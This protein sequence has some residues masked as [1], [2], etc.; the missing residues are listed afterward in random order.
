VLFTPGSLD[1]RYLKIS[2]WANPE[3]DWASITEA[4]AL[5]L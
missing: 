2:F 1:A 5:G 4:G 3:N